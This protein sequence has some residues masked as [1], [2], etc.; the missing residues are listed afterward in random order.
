MK[1][2]LFDLQTSYEKDVSSDDTSLR[3]FIRCN[4]F[5]QELTSLLE[6]IL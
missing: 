3:Y 4:E 5:D 2:D 6:L 1:V